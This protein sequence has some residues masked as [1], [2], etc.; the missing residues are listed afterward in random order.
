M[1]QKAVNPRNIENVQKLKER[2]DEA[3]AIV[4]VDYKGIS[5]Q[6]DTD[7]RNKFRDNKVDYFVAKN[8]LLKL[9]VKDLSIEGLDEYLVGP[10]AIAV[11][12]EDEVT[13]PKL[14]SD[15][16]KSLPD[17]KDF[18]KF[19]V[20]II[21]NQLMDVQELERVVNLPSKQELLAQVVRSFNS[22]ISGLVY[23]LN[24]ILQKLVLVLN[25]IKNKQQS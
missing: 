5:V 17:E 9:A 21:D 14:I 2:L 22:P 19:K 23:T 16:M 18:F 20:G 11:S 15:F 10:T 24:S 4:L 1:E 8:T 25:E 13:P 6:E 12:K 7:L 3:K